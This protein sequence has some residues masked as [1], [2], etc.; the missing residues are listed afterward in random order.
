[1]FIF[2]GILSILF[3]VFWGANSFAQNKKLII[4][5]YVKDS[6]TGESLLNANI[7]IDGSTQSI[8]TNNYGYFSITLTQSNVVLM[9]THA[10]AM[11]K[12]ILLNNLVADT[13]LDVLLVSRAYKKEVD[14]TIKIVANRRV[15]NVRGT[16]M[17]RLD[18]NMAQVKALP[19]LMGEVDILKT[20]QLMPG[21]R[22]AGEGNAG[23]YVRGGGPDQNLVLLDDAVV[24]NPGHLF[25]FFSVFNGDAVK[26][27]TLTKGGMPAQYGGRLSSVIDVVM[28]D[29]NNKKLNVEGGIGLIASRLSIQGPIKNEKTTFFVSARRTYI[30]ALAKPFLKPT[31]NFFGSGYYFYDLNAKL[32]H[33]ISK[34]DKLFLS[35]YFGR[36][37]FDFRSSRNDFSTKIP[38]GNS[39][40]T[41]RWNHISSKKLFI[42]TMALF[43]D[44]KFSFTGIQNDFKFTVRSGIKDVTLKSDADYYLNAN[45]KIKTGIAFTRHTFSPNIAEVSQAGVGFN[46]QNPKLKYAG[47]WALYAQDDWE[48]TKNLKIN[49]GLRYS[50]FNQVGAYTTYKTDAFGNRIDST[51]YGATDIVKSYGGLEPRATIRYALPNN[52]SFK[53]SVVRNLQYIHLVSNNGN[54]LP[55]DL[56]VPSTNFVKPQMSWQYSA[57][58]FKNLKDNAIETSVEV[59][60]KNMLNQIEYKEGYTPTLQDPENEFVFGRGWSYGAEFL[61]NKV[62]GRLT[63]WVGYTLSYTWRKFAQLNNGEKFPSKYDRRH[64]LSVV[65]TYALS[66]K[67]K[68]GA[69]FVYGTGNATTVPERFYLNNGQLVQEYGGLNAYRLKAYHRFDIAATLTPQKRNTKRLKTEWVFSIYNLYSR[70]NPYFIYFSQTGSA[71][72]GTLQVSAKQ[73]S[74][75]PI[76]PSVTW[77]FKF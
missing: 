50:S 25:G 10:S 58:Y 76:L 31:S 47:E 14:N 45:H 5:G 27:A 74:L 28:K 32:S 12:N 60:Y 4:N 1:M 65:G 72:A 22:N 42:N 43:N 20:F 38:W 13:T 59:Y 3:I 52:A 11:P 8:T 55:T 9:V 40:A 48:I 29:G 63:G 18:L 7:A 21:V 37:V 23:F 66:D 30:D 49:Y 33:T 51:V 71:L 70:Q 15:N 64:D 17:G 69:V 68:F 73:V 26:S 41:L 75:F 46:V 6:T 61:V 16:Q 35:G 34:K 67:W 53:A 24:Y 39:T 36:D 2:R 19:V 54:T 77:N 44:Y 62:K 56:W 57:G